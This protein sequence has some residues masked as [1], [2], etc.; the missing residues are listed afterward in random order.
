MLLS[1]GSNGFDMEEL[2]TQ[3]GD[4]FVKVVANL[5]NPD[6]WREALRQPGRDLAALSSST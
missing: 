1:G 2:F 5:T 3:V 6:A 4:I